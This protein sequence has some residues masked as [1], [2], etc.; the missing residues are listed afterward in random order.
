MPSPASHG[1]PEHAS[2]YDDLDVDPYGRSDAWVDTRSFKKTIPKEVLRDERIPIDPDDFDDGEHL[3]FR[4]GVSK[5]VEGRI[6]LDLDM[7]QLPSPPE[8]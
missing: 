6:V 8:R 4:I 3:T 5:D 2:P 7:D 1:P